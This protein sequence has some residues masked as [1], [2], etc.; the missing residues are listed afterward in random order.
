[1]DGSEQ[2]VVDVRSIDEHHSLDVGYPVGQHNG[3]FLVELPRETFKGAWR[4]WVGRGII[5]GG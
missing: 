2:L 1:M 5:L 4:V 3:H